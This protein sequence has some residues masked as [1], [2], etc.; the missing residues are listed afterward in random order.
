MLDAYAEQ[1]YE[2]AEQS[3]NVCTSLAGGSK[4]G[5]LRQRRARKY[6][7]SNLD[8]Q[9]Y[10]IHGRYAC[11]KQQITWKNFIQFLNIEKPEYPELSSGDARIPE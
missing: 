1:C 4:K 11:G 5:K 7:T 10:R 6:R 8:V 2:P 3:V 9:I